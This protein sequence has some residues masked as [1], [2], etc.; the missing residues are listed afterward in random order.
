[1]AQWIKNQPAKQKTQEMQVRSLGRE[2]PLEKETATHSSV[3]AWR[4]PWTEEPSGLQSKK[5]LG[6]TER[7]N[8][9]TFFDYIN[10]SSIITRVLI[11]WEREEEEVSVIQCE[12]NST[13]FH[14]L[15]RW[16]EEA[17][18]QRAWQPLQAGKAEET[19]SPI[20]P[21]EGT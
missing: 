1:M 11:K 8:T 18:S 21:S 2:D 16:K 3:L 12:K 17:T 6:T 10:R 9:F 7:L 14:W 15:C 4:I 20:D 5:E 13:H 19:R